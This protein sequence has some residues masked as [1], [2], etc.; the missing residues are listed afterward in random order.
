VS[1]FDDILNEAD[2]PEV[3]AASTTSTEPTEPVAEAVAEETPV[4]A[5]DVP[6]GADATAAEA[7]PTLPEGYKLDALGRVHGPDGR[8]VSK[9][10]A[11]RIKALAVPAT[12]EAVVPEVPVT[13]EPPAVTPA[14]EPFT[15]RVNGKRHEIPGLVVPPDQQ[16]RIRALLVNG[17]NHEQNFPR[18]QQEWKQRLQQAEQ[19]ADAKSSKYNKASVFL[20]DK[21][22][23]LLQDSPAELQMLQ[24]EVA[25]MLKEADLSLPKAAAP[26]QPEVNEQEM[27]QAA[28]VTLT[29]YVNE[30]LEDTPDAAK[31]FSAEDRK[32]LEQAFQSRLN[33]YFTEH[34]GEIV[35]DMH[36]AKRDFERELRIQ[37]RSHQARE[38]AA[39][40]AQKAKAAAA[41]N[42]A[43]VTKPTASTPSK[44]KPTPAPVA[45]PS[46]Q[47]PGWDQS[48]KSAW[49]EDDTE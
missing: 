48:F 11:E 38:A 42:A 29:G 12:P 15:F 44:P 13:P 46:G 45:A 8:V 4:A 35:L 37:Q 47:R 20:W 18:M 30:L 2:E 49:N 3:E 41:F 21:V 25:L 22:A 28:R 14:P 36:T 9:E 27:E 5:V 24:R 19:M 26:A 6:E 40:D 34:E 31:L 39:R 16:E 17:M 10:E 23:T 43:Q 32:D 33:A 1:D 7:T